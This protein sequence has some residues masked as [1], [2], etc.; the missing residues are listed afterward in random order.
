MTR[1]MKIH[2]NAPASRCKPENARHLDRNEFHIALF[3]H[4][5]EKIRC[6]K[7][8]DFLVSPLK[9]KIAHTVPSLLIDNN[10][11]ALFLHCKV[12]LRKCA[13]GGGGE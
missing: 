4:G 5:D 9:N 1:V 6:D 2:N 11:I 3:Q 7:L 12:C 13:R 10:F 8:K